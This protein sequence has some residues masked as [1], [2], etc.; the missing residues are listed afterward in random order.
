MDVVAALPARAAQGRIYFGHRRLLVSRHHARRRHADH[1]DGGDERLPQGTARQDPRPQRP[2]AGAAAR[3]AADRFRGGSRAHQPARPASRW[4]R[5]SSKGRRSRPRRSMRPACWCAGC[6]SSE[7]TKLASVAKNI[8]QGTLEGFDE[9][10]G[11]A[12]RQ[13][14]RGSI[15]AAR[16]RLRDAGRAA[17]RGDADGHD[18]AHQD[19]QDRGRIRGRHVGIRFRFR[20]HAAPRGA[21][22]F[23]PRRRRHRD[24]GLYRRSRQSRSVS[25]SSSATPRSARSS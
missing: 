23:Q 18:A 3:R 10:Q 16:G 22:L 8:K 21:G 7:L 4:P 12:D 19:L 13:A 6:A 14:A 11:V 20:I 17:R 24:R 15:D 9:G 2:C 1:R 25:Q 5:R